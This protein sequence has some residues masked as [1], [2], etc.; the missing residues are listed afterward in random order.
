[1]CWSSAAAV[2][3]AFLLAVRLDDRVL[4]V[5]IAFVGGAA[6]LCLL[7]A[8]LYRRGERP[9]ALSGG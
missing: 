8:G 4:Q 5:E 1:V 9:E 3:V 6:L 2:F 7:L